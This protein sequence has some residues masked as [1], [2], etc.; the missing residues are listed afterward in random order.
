MTRPSLFSTIAALA[1]LS[2]WQTGAFAAEY[3]NGIKWEKPAIVTP[4]ATNADPPSDAVVLFDGKDLKKWKNGENWRVDDD[5]NARDRQR[6]DHPV[7]M[8]LVIANCTS[9]GLRQHQPKAAA[10]VAATVACS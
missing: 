4:G 5:G 10:R 8:N 7:M 1:V 3:L 2:T 9:N 6:Q